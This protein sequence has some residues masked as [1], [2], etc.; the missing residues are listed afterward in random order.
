MFLD[1]GISRDSAPDNAFLK[2]STLSKANGAMVTNG[3]ANGNGANG[4]TNGT[5]GHANGRN[6]NANGRSDFADDKGVD[7]KAASKFSKVVITQVG[8]P[9]P[10][11]N[12]FSSSDIA[13]PLTSTLSDFIQESPRGSERIHRLL[14]LFPQNL[15]CVSPQWLQ[16]R[17]GQD[18]WR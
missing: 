10:L 8:P 4:H 3:H 1:D 7:S 14:S 15:H 13:A 17:A 12:P 11:P 16:G 18:Y 2:A 6:G 5:N 9:P